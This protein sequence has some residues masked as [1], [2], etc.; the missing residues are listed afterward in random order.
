MPGT[1]TSCASSSTAAPGADGQASRSAGRS[2]PAGARPKVAVSVSFCW[3]RYSVSG[4]FVPDDNAWTSLVSPWAEVT[5]FPVQQVGYVQPAGYI[6][7][8]GY[9]HYRPWACSNHYFR[10]HHWYLCR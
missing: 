6:Q 10:R 4:T 5:A 7:Q 9:W 3:P 1:S 8:V 2:Q